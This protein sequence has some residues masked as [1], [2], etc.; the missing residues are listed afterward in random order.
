MKRAFLVFP[1]QLFVSNY[2]LNKTSH[3]FLIEDPLYFTQYNFHKK[4]LILHRA[5]MR[6]Y[7]ASL[8]A[9]GFAVSYVEFKDFGSTK[10]Y[11]QSIS[12]LGFKQISYKDTCDD[13]LERRLT[14]AAVELSISISRLESDMFLSPLSFLN[15]YFLNRKDFLMGNFYIAQRKRLSI[16]VEGSSPVGGKWSF[17]TENRKKLPKSISVPET[18]QPLPNDFVL[19]S[20]SYIHQNFPSNYGDGN[21]FHYPINHEDAKKWLQDFLE[22]RFQNFGIYEDAIS[23]DHTFLFHGVLTPMLNT[24]LL[25]PKQVVDEVISYALSNS[26]PLNSLEGFLRQIIGWRE[27]MRAAYLFRGAKERTTNFWKHSRKIPS[28]FW[29]GTTGIEPLDTVISRLLKYGYTHHIERLMVLGNFMLLCEF[30]PDEVYKWFMEIH[31]CLRLGDGAK[32]L[33]DESICGRWRYY[34]QALYF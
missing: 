8:A 2:N 23:K 17:D 34:H 29:K 24:G 25:T 12:D 4:K 20:Y 10:D 9:H 18:Y 21:N 13:W 26:I 6:S 32:R 19:D 3:F 7:G 28:S 22:E 5:S 11:L 1:H 14:K 30:D 27:Y 33:W 31:R 16:L 15:E